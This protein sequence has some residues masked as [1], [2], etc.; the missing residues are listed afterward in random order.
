MLPLSLEIFA[1]SHT[2][3]FITGALC[4]LRGWF[5]IFSPVSPFRA[6]LCSAPRIYSDGGGQ[7]YW[8]CY[9]GNVVSVSR[10]GE[11]PDSVYT[12]PAQSPTRNSFRSRSTAVVHSSLLDYAVFICCER[13]DG[14]SLW[15]F[16]RSLKSQCAEGPAVWGR[17]AWKAREVQSRYTSA[18]QSHCQDVM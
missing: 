14:H 13:H 7:L 15:C 18:S 10:A 1:P 4:I 6:T 12:G 9:G 17:E 3:M 16:F 5:V 2:S 11:N 8:K